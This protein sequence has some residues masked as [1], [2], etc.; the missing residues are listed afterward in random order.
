MSGRQRSYAIIL[1][2]LDIADLDELNWIPISTTVCSNSLI[3]HNIYMEGWFL[4]ARCVTGQ[5]LQQSVSAD[6]PHSLTILTTP[7]IDSTF[8]V[9]TTFANSDHQGRPV[10]FS[11]VY[12]MQQLPQVLTVIFSP[13][14]KL[15]FWIEWVSCS[16]VHVHFPGQN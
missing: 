7:L 16:A 11:N 14:F 13:K 4:M 6:L 2:S 8:T 9:L 3:T 10:C 1:L 12:F 5:W 15:T